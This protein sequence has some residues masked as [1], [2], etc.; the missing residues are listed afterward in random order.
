MKKTTELATLAKAEE[1]IDNE[2]E[3]DTDDEDG[4]D[5]DDCGRS[6]ICTFD[7]PHFRYI[8]EDVEENKEEARERGLRNGTARTWCSFSCEE[9]CRD[10]SSYRYVVVSGTPLKILEHLLSDLRLDEQRGAPESGKFVDM[11]HG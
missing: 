9:D 1:D 11:A 2:D 8:D 3:E 7:V 4:S 6:E 5:G 10:S